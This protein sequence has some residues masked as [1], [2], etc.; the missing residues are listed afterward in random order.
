MN[1][2]LTPSQLKPSLTKLP[3]D[4]VRRC[5]DTADR[6]FPDARL[7]IN[8]TTNVWSGYFNYE[9]GSY[10]MQIENLLMKGARI[11]GIGLQFHMFKPEAKLLEELG[12]YYNPKRLFDVMDTLGE[13]RRPLSISEITVPAYGG[14]DEAKES[15]AEVTELLYRIWFSHP[16]ADSIVWWNLVDGTAAYAPLGSSQG[17]N[18]YH[19]GL[20]NFDMTPKPVWETLDRL[21]N[22]EWH[23]E[24]DL[25]SVDGKAKLHGFYGDYE[26]TVERG[27]VTTTHRLSLT[28]SG[29]SNFTLKA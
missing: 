10:Y 19:G 27:G 1:E 22:H 21:I 25:A 26:L 29:K 3:R 18:Y 15:Q 2:S 24:C 28:K 13:F 11:D 9:Y 7:F 12:T 14:T 5:F 17:E 4:Y 16:M 20:L 6:S 23:T 8:E